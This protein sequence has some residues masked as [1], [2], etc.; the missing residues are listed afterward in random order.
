MISKAKNIFFIIIF[1]TSLLSI[2]YYYFSENNIVNTMKSRNNYEFYKIQ[3][4]IKIP[5]LKNDTTD[6]I[7]YT[8]G[9]DKY[10]KSK[11]ECYLICHLIFNFLVSCMVKK[12]N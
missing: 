6:I 7:E 9:L 1:F 8:D 5:L 11:Q 4:L 3:N 10:K 2:L 12:L